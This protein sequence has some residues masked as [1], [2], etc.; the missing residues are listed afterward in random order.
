MSDSSAERLRT[1]VAEAVDRIE[2][3]GLPAL[4]D[5]CT[6]NPSLASAIRR[7]VD[8][9]INAGFVSQL[10]GGPA[11]SPPE[12]LGDFRIIRRLGQGG[13]GIVYLAEQ[14][15]L[16]R[17]V[18]IKFIRPEH[19]YF[20]NSRERFKREIDAIARLQH[21]G[22]VPV[23][24]V[25]EEHGIPFFSMEH[26]RGC[27]LSDVLETLRGTA[28]AALTGRSLADAIGA[29]LDDETNDKE[30]RAASSFAFEGTWTEACF[31][32]VAQIADALEHAHRHG[33]FH[34]D[35]KPSNLMI[36]KTG[37]VLLLDFGLAATKGAAQLTRAGAQLGSLHYL[38]PEQVRGDVDAINAT[39]DVYG[40]GVTLY[41]L[42]TLQLPFVEESTE[43]IMRRILEGRPRPV[44]KLN[45]AVPWDAETV[46]L[47]AMERE[48]P[49]RYKSAADLA[50]DVQN[51]LQFRPI[52]A[53]R[54]GVLLRVRRFSQR[55]PGAAAA[56]A[57]AAICCIGGPSFYAYVEHRSNQKLQSEMNHSE[58]LRL[59][60]ASGSLLNKDPALALLVALEGG[61]RAPGA[62]AKTALLDAL[63]EMHE[64]RTLDDSAGRCSDAA[65]C[66]DDAHFAVAGG[67]GVARIYNSESGRLERSIYGHTGAVLSVQ[68]SGDGARL[69]TTSADRT[70][71]V[72][73]A[74]S[75][76][77]ILLI[78]T[79]HVG[80]AQC[81]FVHHDEWIAAAR[82]GGD[83]VIID[84][85]S[86]AEIRT[87]SGH[88][89]TP[90]YLERS[91]DGQYLLS[92]SA[93]GTIRLWNLNDPAPPRIFLASAA[94]KMARLSPD[95]R[96]ILEI[97]IFSNAVTAWDAAA[98]EK[99]YIIG[100]D[101]TSRLKSGEH[102]IGSIS[103]AH[104]A[105]VGYVEFSDD[106]EWFATASGDHMAKIWNAADGALIR[107]FHG[108]DK[109]LEFA[110]LSS[111][112]ALLA[113]MGADYNICIWNAATGAQIITLRGHRTAV[114]AARFSRDGSR[115][116]SLGGDARLWRP[117]SPR[118]ISPWIGH[119]D[120]LN[121][122]FFSLDRTRYVTA[123][124]D[125]TARVWDARTSDL[126]Y[127]IPAGDARLSFACFSND[128]Q[129][130]A[131][132]G[133]TNNIT[134]WNVPS[135]ARVA[136]LWGHS[137]R[138]QQVLFDRTG[139]RVMTCGDDGIL[140]IWDWLSG[141][142]PLALKPPQAPSPIRRAIY[143]YDSK[144]IASV[145]V[146]QMLNIWDAADNCLLYSIHTT[147]SHPSSLAF[148]YEGWRVAIGA[149]DEPGAIYD[150][151][152]GSPP[153]AIDQARDLVRSIEFSR[154][155]RFVVTA[156]GDRTVKLWNSRTG[157]LHAAFQ[158]HRT[159]LLAASFAT[160]DRHVISVSQDGI[161][162][163]WPVDPDA[164]AFEKSPRSLTS[165][166]ASS[167]GISAPAANPTE[168]A[169]DLNH[170]VW[171]TVQLSTRSYEKDRAA[172]DAAKRLCE[173]T[174]N[175]PFAMLARAAAELRAE[176][177]AAALTTL[178]ELARRKTELTHGQQFIASA[179]AA[180]AR[181]DRAS[182]S[183]LLDESESADP[184]ERN[185]IAEL[186]LN[187]QLQKS[188]GK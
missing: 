79:A 81:I 68:F 98:G 171:E 21:P 11:P 110:T 90:H 167:F 48:Q 140:Y 97:D 175:A 53:R 126:L 124:R 147:I 116:V 92:A 46:C 25:G 153:V 13:M 41:E 8:A 6:K 183:T 173:L 114:N 109:I 67:D 102:A 159:E 94:V 51:V 179:L 165:A 38:S 64:I 4:D 178:E 118:D 145:S 112:R 83:I 119:E 16:K 96:T 73:D 117:A 123:S 105:P 1:L 70:A 74:A 142:P 33:V 134:I 138:I 82:R 5:L 151:T 14:L 2:E 69:L 115:L 71:R 170:R 78:E 12:R 28:A 61:R 45:A 100:G 156:S 86:G 26:I 85:N 154:D 52:E 57:L 187:E 84:A 185:T 37:R 91:R 148:D 104:R 125:G 65:F 89:R 160:D 141:A 35:L 174:R 50:R 99:K 107:T 132:C 76:A 47:T 10:G 166:E 139:T 72:F 39:T 43:G 158:G 3:E 23:Y 18:A 54:P 103:D 30:R 172:L 184:D 180:L 62:L 17:E 49:R 127:L 32:I 143:S 169:S 122:G 31:R 88:S 131:T 9:L 108:H 120:A 87:L 29:Q 101:L 63:R 7:R 135:G 106:G 161:V 22:I 95:A 20:S 182:A 152:S 77:Q 177:G 136:S 80:A 181:D 137:G 128:G 111:D 129:F 24:T 93:D 40:L 133:E 42:L 75:G 130:V 27:P 59:I 176:S 44:R 36:T 150:I 162:Y 66:A 188:A 121:S 60:A 34:R 164:E 149:R 157:E 55:R 186:L 146:N 56:A 144:L 15:S 168:S 155:G 113:T 19:L 58:G 163:N